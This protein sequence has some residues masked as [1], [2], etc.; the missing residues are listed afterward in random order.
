MTAENPQVVWHDHSVSR[1]NR[2][3]HNGHRGCVLWFTGLSGSGKS[4]IAN[5]VDVLL[6]ERGAHSFLLDGDNIRHGLCAGPNLLQAEHD[7]AFA[8]RFGLGFGPLDR[9]ENIRRVGSV[10][11]LFASAGLIVLTAFVSPYRRDRARVRK[12]VEQQG[13]PGDFMEVFVD[14]PLEVCEARDPKGLYKQARAGKISNFTGI[15]DPYEPPVAP[16]IH[17]TDVTRS[18]GQLAEEVIKLLSER[19]VLP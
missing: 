7:E 13:R 1:E 3:Q 4:T 16:E 12:W 15:S 14:T 5:A 17:L 8:T 18:P 11:Q 2:E 19:G 6:H 10:A 9:E